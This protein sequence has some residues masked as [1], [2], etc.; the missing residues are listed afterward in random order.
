MN[1]CLN[2]EKVF[3]YRL[4]IIGE[5]LHG[6]LF[7]SCFFKLYSPPYLYSCRLKEISKVISLSCMLEETPQAF[8]IDN[9]A[10][11]G[12]RSRLTLIFTDLLT[13]SSHPFL[14]HPYNEAIGNLF[15]MTVMSNLIKRYTYIHLHTMTGIFT[16][17]I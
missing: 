2:V 4:V 9:E 6:H 13:S 14:T 11:G 12:W 17:S 5:L 3:L 10:V 15:S 16:K 8:W 7:T 1:D